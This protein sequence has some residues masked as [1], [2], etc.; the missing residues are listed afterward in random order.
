MGG[1]TSR[2]RGWPTSGQGRPWVDLRGAKEG[3]DV[4]IPVGSCPSPHSPPTPQD[5]NFALMLAGS[6]LTR[7]VG[8]GVPR[9]L[10]TSAGAAAG[11]GAQASWGGEAGQPQG[12][13]PALGGA[14]EG[15]LTPVVVVGS[16][17]RAARRDGC[18]PSGP[19]RCGD[20]S[21]MWAWSPHSGVDS[22]SPGP[23]SRPASEWF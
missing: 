18:H 10:C 4:V 6:A 15:L 2:K 11:R 8:H 22:E 19:A 21:K 13:S 5:V 7:G 9:E 16:H 12:S 1:W 23:V 14:G 20:L 3:Q 17:E